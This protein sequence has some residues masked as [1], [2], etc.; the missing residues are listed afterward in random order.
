MPA[1]EQNSS[2]ENAIRFSIVITCLTALTRYVAG[3]IS[4]AASP[5]FWVR[6]P[7]A[8]SR[9]AFKHALPTGRNTLR[10]PFG[11]MNL[12]KSRP[13]ARPC[14]QAA[15]QPLSANGTAVGLFWFVGDV[16]VAAGVQLSDA[17][18]YGD[19]LT[20]DGGHMD[21]WEKWR[22]VGSA[23]LKRNGLP[24]EILQTEYDAHPRGRVVFDQSVSAFVIYADAR[25]HNPAQIAC[26]RQRF[27]LADQP[28]I[29]RTDAHY[30]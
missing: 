26:L 19:C 1:S 2:M 24:I 10:L 3:Y 12:K 18:R 14:T 8:V 4:D 22:K 28:V 21:H 9:Y 30:R 13:S 23:W 25:L 20:Y 15:P 29:V 17:V 7:G 5:S 16:L 27:S 11:Q 6:C